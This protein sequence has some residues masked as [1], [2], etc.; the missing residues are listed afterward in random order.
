MELGFWIFNSYMSWGDELA[1]WKHQDTCDSAS[2]LLPVDNSL[3]LGKIMIPR[4]PIPIDADTLGLPHVCQDRCAPHI[5]TASDVQRSSCVVVVPRLRLKGISLLLPPIMHPS[6]TDG[7]RER[8]QRRRK[9]GA[10][11]TTDGVGEQH[12]P[13]QSV[14]SSLARP[15]RAACKSKCIESKGGNL[16]EH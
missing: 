5:I 1:L 6:L 16:Y 3:F 7:G 2:S 13:P 12:G 10:S 8:T 9:M 14:M 4:R 11:N 15:I